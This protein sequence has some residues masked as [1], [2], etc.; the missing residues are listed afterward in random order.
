MFADSG[1]AGRLV[2]SAKEKAILALSIVKRPRALPRFEVMP[3][4]WVV[5]RTFGWS[6][7]KGR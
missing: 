7:R 6:T 5:E 1:Y 4:R 3:R 2:A